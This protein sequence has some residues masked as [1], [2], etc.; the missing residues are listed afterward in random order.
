M[1][2]K[3]SLKYNLTCLLT[4]ILG[5]NMVSCVDNNES[6][7]PIK[8]FVP[9]KF[10]SITEVKALYDGELAKTDY[11]TRVPVEITEALTIKG[12]ITTDDNLNG[13]L[14]KEAYIED[15]TGG[16]LLK[17]NS[18]GALGMG[19]SVMINL[20]GL[21]LGDYGNFI[22]LG[23]EPYTDNSGNRRV[24]NIEVDDCMSRFSFLNAT[25]PTN[26]NLVELKANLNNYLG[27]LVKIDDV[28]FADSEL[29]NDYAVPK[30]GNTEADY[31]N[32]KLEDCYKN[33]IIVRSSGYSTFAGEKLPQGNG[34]IVGIVTKFNTTIQLIIR[35]INEVK[36]DGERCSGIPGGTVEGDGTKANPYNVAYILGGT[37]ATT[38]VWVK[39]YIVGTVDGMSFQTNLNITGPTFTATSN[40]VL[41]ASATE[42]NPALMI[43]VQV[44]FGDLRTA[45]NLVDNAGNHKKLVYIKGQLQ[46]Y[47]SVNGIKTITGYWWPDSNTGVDPD[48]G[49][50]T[51]PGTGVVESI[52]E[53]FDAVTNETD[54]A[55]NGWKN[56]MVAGSRLW[57]GKTFTNSST[58]TTDKYAQATGYK[59]TEDNL[60]CWLITPQVTVKSAK[61]ISFETA[62]SYWAH[63]DGNN[64]FEVFYSSNFDGTNVTA[65]NWTKINATTASN[66]DADNAWIPSG[67]IDLPVIADKNIVIGF[68]YKGS[69]TETTTIRIDNITITNK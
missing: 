2:N 58:G 20:K 46:T 34:S 45:L 63:A 14:Y 57:R 26:V 54:I 13:N 41:A 51:D 37:P 68:K 9:G 7:P 40:I 39:G 24:G 47:F 52:D 61:T 18:T 4:L 1:K 62:K 67:T 28:Q 59:A 35:D 5:L 6:D 27:R 11:K 64:P 60:E 49:G 10:T 44:P 65:A 43:P 31:G 36:M 17:L 19:D 42:T 33:N 56:I 69:K 16:L 50:T 30:E 22:Q 55:L 25:T 12:I 21:F 8:P 32:R 29:E 66:S 38:D 3:F 48:N 23:S 53:K 15:A